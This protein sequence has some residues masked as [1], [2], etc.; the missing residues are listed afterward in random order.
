[1][2]KICDPYLYLEAYVNQTV[3]YWYPDVQYWVVATGRDISDFNIPTEEKKNFFI[4]VINDYVFSY[5]S[6]VFLGLFWS[7]GFAVWVFIIMAG[8]VSIRHSKSRLL[9]FLPV[10]GVYITLLIATPVYS[11]FR[12]IYSLFT[13]MPIFC[14][15]PFVNSKNDNV[16]LQNSTC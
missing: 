11:E 7:I 8:A 5:K 9:V 13:S 16:K 14:I 12:Y 6:M 15:I 1:M 2:W 3:G 4:D 10:L